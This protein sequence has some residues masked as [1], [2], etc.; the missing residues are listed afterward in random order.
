MKFIFF[1]CLLLTITSCVQIPTEEVFTA[2][3]NNDIETISNFYKFTNNLE[4]VEEQ[5]GMTP[6]LAA[7]EKG[8][9]SIVYILLG[10]GE[11][12]G[13]KKKAEINARDK[14][15][16]T[17]LEYAIIQKNFEAAKALI[18]NG[19][20]INEKTF[21]Q[22]TLTHLIVMEQDLDL[23][24][25]AIK[26]GADVNAVDNYGEP[27]LFYAITQKKIIELLIENGSN[28][29]TVNNAGDT[30]LHKAASSDN[31]ELL[32]YLV[33]KGADLHVKN[34]SNATPMHIAAEK[35]N[36]EIV[37][38]C[39]NNGLDIHA[40]T[41][42]RNLLYNAALSSNSN[43]VKYC[44]ENGVEAPSDGKFYELII[45]NHSTAFSNNNQLAAYCL[46]NN[47]D[48]APVEMFYYALINK[49]TSVARAFIDEGV[50]ISSVTN[51]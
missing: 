27:P 50:D 37:T 48:M 51:N 44:I 36:L 32:K 13:S 47:S 9:F 14:L 20:D 46:Q 29:D 30:I 2:T 5:S 43:L 11:K 17:A 41:R 21:K 35:G 34:K 42:N 15:G 24:K 38:Y 10:L 6:L 3:R 7:A 40:K 45:K 18:E 8:N 19:A 39:I 26:H 31:F 25:T 23:V 16:N 33:E 28:I 12:S 49:Q 1:I 22:A 4:I